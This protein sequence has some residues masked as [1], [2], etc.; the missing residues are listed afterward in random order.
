MNGRKSRDLN[1]KADDLLKDWIVRNASNPEDLDD[2]NIEKYLPQDT[3]FT[4]DV[5]RK[6]N[7]YTKRWTIRKLKK[8]Q[9]RNGSIPEDLTIKKML[10]V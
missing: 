2:S 10:K 9:K 3:H 1:K 6:T 8:I 4:D 7:F 5:S